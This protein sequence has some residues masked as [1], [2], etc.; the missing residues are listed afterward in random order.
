MDNIL[1][2][3]VKQSREDIFDDRLGTLLRKVMLS[4]QFGFQIPSIAD[5]G[6]DV[7]V[8]VGC[9]NLKASEDVGMIKFLEDIDF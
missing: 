6:N 9:E 4:S 5:F 8:A 3:K 1:L 7:T 2:C